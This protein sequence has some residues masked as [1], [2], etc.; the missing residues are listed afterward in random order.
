ML[1]APTIRFS[2]PSYSTP[3]VF[4]GLLSIAFALLAL[5]T[6]GLGLVQ[7][8]T[9]VLLCALGCIPTLIICITQYVV[10]DRDIASPLNFFLL[11]VFLGTTVN[12]YYVVLV[13]TDFIINHILLDK[14]ITVLEPGLWAIITGVIFF[15]VGYLLVDSRSLSIKNISILRN[16]R[17]NDLWVKVGLTVLIAVATLCAILY[18]KDIGVWK[19]LQANFYTHF[20][21]KHQGLTASGSETPALGYFQWGAELYQ[22]AFLILL[23]RYLET[24]I[25]LISLKS[26]GLLLLGLLS[27]LIPFLMSSRS[28]LI[29]VILYA[30][31]VIHYSTGGLRMHAVILVASICV[32]IV[33]GMGII[34]YV[35]QHNLSQNGYSEYA[36]IE[37]LYESSV[38]NRHF[39][40]PAKTS[41]V[42]DGVP[43]ELNYQL[44]RTFVLWLIAPI[45]RRIWPGKPVVRIGGVLGPALFGDPITSG[46]PPGFVGEL[47]FNFGWPG[48][49]LGMFVLGAFLRLLRNSFVHLVIDSKSARLIYIYFLLAFAYTLPS[50]DFTGAMTRLILGV[51]PMGLILWVVGTTARAA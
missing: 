22:I 47:Y 26:F 30:L 37:D 9:G 35:Q 41:H 17:W 34:R 15:S 13:H 44:G 49:P 29:Y 48:I 16:N 8:D 12:T 36:N 18:L 3:K 33:G 11:T 14:P 2:G 25:P 45:P 28:Q 23:A 27:I 31:V 24:R 39:L 20:S 10:G 40:A 51:L 4:W 46:T 5:A 19:A 21:T 7:E 42:I 32:V 6:F 38:G 1:S 43:R 50:E